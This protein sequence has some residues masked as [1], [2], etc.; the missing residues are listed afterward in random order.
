MNFKG[1][2]DRQHG[3]SVLQAPAVSLSELAWL[4]QVEQIRRE[5][6]DAMADAFIAASKD[7]ETAEGGLKPS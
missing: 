6:G 5:Y 3:K 2:Q 1:G 4:K 7:K